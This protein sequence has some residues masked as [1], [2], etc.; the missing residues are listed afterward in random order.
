[1]PDGQKVEVKSGGSV[2]NTTQLQEMGQ[3]A[4]DATG[5][6]LVVVTTNPNATVT[7][8]VQKNPNIKIKPV[9]K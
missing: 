3:G 9:D 2:S 1:M 7:V 6:P 8:P 4:M 5:K